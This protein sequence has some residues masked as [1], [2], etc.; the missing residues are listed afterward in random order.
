MA[1]KLRDLWRALDRE[2]P[3]LFLDPAVASGEYDVGYVGPGGWRH[4]FTK[5]NLLLY[6]WGYVAA[7]C[8]GQGD[9]T[10]KVAAA[11]LEYENVTNPSD[12]VSVPSYGRADGLSYYD[13]LG[14]NRDFLRV[15]LAGTPSIDVSPGYESYFTTGGN[16]VTFDL[17]SSGTAG[18]LGRPFSDANNSKAC[19]VALVATP[20]PADRTQDVILA[21]GY[22]DVA[23][24]PLKL[25]GSQ[26]GVRWKVSFR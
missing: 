16:R 19:G 4:L 10:F 26:I 22:F 2:F 9:A 5:R 23:D 18:V 20:S 25:A 7:K 3:G 1:G 11:Y 6:T 21:R 12:A 17:Q 14:A 8:V 24:Q 13:G 15:A